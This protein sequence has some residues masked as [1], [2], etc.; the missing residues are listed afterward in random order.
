MNFNELGLSAPVLKA[1]AELGFENPTEVQQQAIPVVLNTGEDV[2]ALAQTG[3]GKT[4]AFGLPMLEMTDFNERNI[5]SLIICPTREL[6]LQISKDIEGYGKYLD[7]MRV[8]AIYGGSS[9][10]NQIRDVRR[11]AQVIVA[12]PGR[13][14]DLMR[15]NVVKLENVK[16]VVLD[17]AD[18]MLNMG[19][20]ED[21]DA[22][23]ESTPPER[24][25]LLF[26]AT[27]P[28]EVARIAKKYM[29]EPREIT[30]GKKNSGAATVSHFWYCVTERDRYLALRRLLDF[31]PD[32]FGLVFCRTRVETQQVADK[33]QV[34]GYN[35]LPLHG[36]MS[37]AMRD[38]AMKK[39]RDRTIQVL[40]ATDVAARGIDV[41]DITHV[42]HYNLPD[43]IENYNHR[44]GRT[45][46]AGKSG[47]S[48]TIINK[49]ELHK[50]RAI[51]KAMDKEFTHGQIPTAQQIIEKQVYQ[52]VSRIAETDPN[53]FQLDQYLEKANAMFGEMTREEI[54]MR[55]IAAEF[56]R[57]SDA[58][59]FAGDI[60]ADIKGND[61]R[62]DRDDRFDRDRSGDRD[63]GG[64]RD[65]DRQ[66]DDRPKSKNRNL[67]PGN[68]EAFAIT[69]GEI[70]NM[71]KGALVRLVCSVAG[72]TSG[73]IG[74]IQV[75]ADR[76]FF[77]V[78]EKSATKVK[79]MFGKPLMYGNLDVF[80]EAH[81][82]AIPMGGGFKG[83]GRDGGR[84]YGGGS[85]GG[86]RGYS[87]GGSSGGGRSYGGGG[88]NSGGGGRSYGGGG[89]SS[90]GGYKRNTGG[91]SQGSGGK[92]S[93]GKRGRKKF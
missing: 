39:F 30:V 22:I 8:V 4:A 84:G 7:G 52:F 3:T 34:D 54:I 64:S 11:G 28:K 20:Q 32:I 60:N 46:R 12:T 35:A 81:S 92:D 10:E 51:G 14:M 62:R 61:S 26:S 85:S 65:F 86:G 9:I 71:N 38:S 73:E 40:V 77:E 44:S 42:I 90:G 83:G 80:I 50:V 21:I 16:T 74:R 29:R 88:G 24:R 23:L 13:L 68:T 47:I 15:R 63:R 72:I 45:G 6:C 93:G 57:F 53:K 75:S 18:E 82:G 17:E 59:Q 87:G 70:D 37:Q 41:N 56:V 55:V 33:L 1:I 78:D 27:M 91:G 48:L 43:D 69:A 67:S 31:H 5:Q 58:Y 2:V 25:T 49:R 19:F 36:D 89:A 66:D 76:S 79:N